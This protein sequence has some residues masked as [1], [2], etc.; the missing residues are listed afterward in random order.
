VKYHHRPI[1]CTFLFVLLSTVPG[2]WDGDAFAEDT[3]PG[4]SL[5][6]RT[7]P[8]TH[9]P[10]ETGERAS[11]VVL[12]NIQS[13]EVT[14]SGTTQDVTVSSV[15]TLRSVLFFNSRLNVNSPAK[16]LVKGALLDSTTLRF[17]K[18]NTAASATVRWYLVEFTSGVTVTRGT[19]AQTATTINVTIPTVDL[20]ESFVLISNERSGN[21]FSSDDF[22]RA[23]LT[24]A[25]N[26]ELRV[27]SGSGGNVDWQVVEVD[28]ASVQRGTVALG[29][30]SLTQ[31][32][33][34]CSIAGR[35]LQ[36][37]LPISGRS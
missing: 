24:S 33:L 36:A 6:L 29:G 35:P 1:I 20:T 7:G 25:T 19:A 15:D 26:L 11:S 5:A 9:K 28:S 22:W 16:G 12:S 23:R 10:P 32:E 13:G 21:G 34:S 27:D 14:V 31:H 3:P 30:G 17:V 2:V 37:L 4:A 8:G 18:N